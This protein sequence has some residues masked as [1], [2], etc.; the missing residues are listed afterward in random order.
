MNLDHI[1][2]YALKLSIANLLRLIFLLKIL[3]VL[4]KKKKKG[5]EK[6]EVVGEAGFY[7]SKYIYY[8]IRLKYKRR[9]VEHLSPFDKVL[10]LLTF[11]LAGHYNSW[12]CIPIMKRLM[13]SAWEL[14]LSEIKD[15][16]I[17][18]L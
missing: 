1:V 10:L 6:E 15:D 17:F 5:H 2:F 13:G 4:S 14:C 18:A 12:N 9:E 8:K 3:V 7:I 16:I 11:S